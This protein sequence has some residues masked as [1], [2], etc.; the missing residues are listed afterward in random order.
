MWMVKTLLMPLLAPVG[1]SVRSGTQIDMLG[2]IFFKKLSTLNIVDVTYI[3][4]PEPNSTFNINPDAI[5][6]GIV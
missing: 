2:F 6:S 5:Y 4:A 3:N 1:I